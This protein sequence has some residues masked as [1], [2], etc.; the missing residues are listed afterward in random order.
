MSIHDNLKLSQTKCDV[1]TQF[2]PTTNDP[3]KVNSKRDSL[4]HSQQMIKI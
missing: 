3:S 1:T 2:G 4:S